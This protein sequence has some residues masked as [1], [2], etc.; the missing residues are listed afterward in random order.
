MLVQRQARCKRECEALRYSVW[1]VVRR[2]SPRS[3]ALRLL[4]VESDINGILPAGGGP[5]PFISFLALSRLR[6]ALREV[7]AF[8]V[9]Q[10]L[11]SFLAAVPA[12]AKA[13]GE[14]GAQASD[15]DL[16]FG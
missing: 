3:A 10:F 1:L 12:S 16:R 4:K 15:D 9:R 2:F 11:G 7:T 6:S 13:A 5:L 14:L 8:C